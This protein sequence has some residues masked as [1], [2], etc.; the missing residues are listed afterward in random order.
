MIVTT[1][2]FEIK[3]DINNIR[4]IVHVNKSRTLMNYVQEN[5]RAKRDEEKNETIVIMKERNVKLKNET[6]KRF[7]KKECRRITLNDYLNEFEKRIKC[8]D[9]KKKCDKCEERNE[10]NKNEIEKKNQNQSQNEN[11]K[12]NQNQN[13]SQNENEKKN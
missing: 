7:M 1:S 8:E 5:N 13:Q 10:K 9:E 12:E 3:I 4:E 2:T 6:M 11:E